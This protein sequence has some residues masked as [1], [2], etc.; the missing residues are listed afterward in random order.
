MASLQPSKTLLGLCDELLL[1][2]FAFLDV[3]ELLSASRQRPSLSSI[4]PPTSTIYLSSTYLAGRRLSRSLIS[5]RLNRSLSHRPSASSLI[6]VN[7][8]PEECCRHDRETG[9]VL[10]GGGL[11]PSII[12]VKR[13]VEREKVKDGLRAWLA[14]RA[15][16][17]ERRS[18]RGGDKEKPSVRSLVQRFARR[19]G[20][21][22]GREC[23]WSYPSAEKRRRGGE[24]ARANV[25]GLRKFWEGVGMQS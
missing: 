2:I 1:H 14:G 3:P 13:K 18:Q 21:K 23:R 15:E 6:S 11:A 12:E 22:D 8:L 20:G 10:W 17:V 4:A 7:I 25:L 9:E 16:V 19:T 5:I 24:P